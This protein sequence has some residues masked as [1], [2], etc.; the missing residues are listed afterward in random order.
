M[1]GKGPKR[2]LD[3]AMLAQALAQVAELAKSEGVRIALLGGFAL[4]HYGSDRLTGD[5]DVAAEERV[6]GLPRGTPLSFGGEQTEAPNGVPVD[7]VVRDDDYAPLYEEALERA[8]RV[9]GVP[10][11]VVRPE[12]LAAMKMVAGRARD[13]AD[14][15]FLLTSGTADPAKT[16]KIIKKHLGPYAAQEFDRIVD[17]TAWKA[18]R[19]RL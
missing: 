10:V 19:G 3:P 2:F 18:S 14:L 9:R 13:T 12:Y 1:T 5:I 11:P 6:H 16:R 17:E 7:V 8:P 15:E 4:Q